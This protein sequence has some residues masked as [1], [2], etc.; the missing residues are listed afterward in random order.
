MVE[1]YRVGDYHSPRRPRS[2]VLPLFLL[3]IFL[4]SVV[5]TL[6]KE[7]GRVRDEYS[8]LALKSARDDLAAARDLIGLD[9][10]G[11]LDRLLRAKDILNQPS[12][13]GVGPRQLDAFRQEVSD[14]ENLLLKINSVSSHLVYDFSSQG[15]G[16]EVTGLA[17]DNSA[18]LLVLD[19]G[20]GQ[21]FKVTV[22]DGRSQVEK[23]PLDIPASA[24]GLSFFDG[25]GLVWGKD[26]VITFSEKGESLDTV[27]IGSCGD[28]VDVKGYAGSAYILSSSENQI[29]KSSLKPWLKEQLELD[30]SARLAI[31]GDIYLWAGDTL[32]RFQKGREADF[33]FQEGVGKPL[34]SP[35]DIVTWAGSGG[36]YILDS[37]NLRVLKF[38]KDGALLGQY[39]DS[40]WDDLRALAIS[41]DEAKGYVLSGN[42]VLEFELNQ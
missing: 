28:V 13:S 38:S 6:V 12:V 39:V 27:S 33:S 37:I 9:D 35:A 1:D 8:F 22:Q 23:Y 41:S 15:K 34:I 40:G 5:F 7:R 30:S 10:L 20:Q 2:L 17:F 19:G 31:D 11:A 18:H 4:G 14:V 16:V 24:Q 32:R 26:T 21:V 42:K 29:F 25:V 36:I 3:I